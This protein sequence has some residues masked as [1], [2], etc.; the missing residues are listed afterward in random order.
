MS[1]IYLCGCLLTAQR[2]RWAHTST[3]ESRFYY[4]EIHI[5]IYSI[6]YDNDSYSTDTSKMC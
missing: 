5:L 1:L 2:S 3:V 4:R 6:S